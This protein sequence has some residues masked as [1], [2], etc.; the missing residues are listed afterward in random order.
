MN[1][2]LKVL[3]TAL[4]VAVGAWLLPGV[5]MGES[6]WTLLWVAALIG[7]FN[8][9]IKPIFIILT[10]PITIVTLG[11]FLLAVNAIMLLLVD[12]FV[13]G[14]HIENFW[15]ALLLSLVISVVRSLVERNEEKE[16]PQY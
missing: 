6:I 2:I 1:W 11:L 16:Q 13:D 4:A 3:V 15:W 7:F 9:V 14:F 12:K 10:I 8:A 5:E